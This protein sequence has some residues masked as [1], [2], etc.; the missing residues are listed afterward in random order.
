MKP[1]LPQKKVTV[2]SFKS[3]DMD[4]FTSDLKSSCLA[5]QQS[6]SLDELCRTYDN[7]LRSLLDKHAPEKTITVTE[8]P[9]TPWYND[10]INDAKKL[11]RKY[12]RLMRQPPRLTIHR[13]M[14]LEQAHV[15]TEMI[16]AAKTSYFTD[17]VNEC[18][19]DQKALFRIIGELQGKKKCALLP[20]FPTAMDAAE[21]FSEFFQ[22]K[23]STIR[24][25]LDDADDCIDQPLHNQTVLP[26]TPRECHSILDAFVPL[27]V[28][29][30]KKIVTSS[31]SKS[32]SIDPIPTWLLKEIVDD[33]VP[34][35][36]IIVN[37]SL[38]EGYFPTMFKKA[39][40]TPLLKKPSLDKEL[41]KNYRPVSN[42]SF[43]SKVTEKAAMSQVSTYVSSNRLLTKFQ[44]A[45]RPFHS[46]E[47]A[48]LRVQNDLLLSL[49]QSKGI[50]MTLLDLSAAFDTCDH[51]ILMSRLHSNMGFSGS[52]LNWFH[53]YLEDRFQSVHVNGAISSPRLLTFGFPQ[54]S[55]SG[56]QDY[57][58][59]SAEVPEVALQHGV[60]VHTY[61]DDTQLY[62]QFELSS[63]E[64][65]EAAVV[66]MEDCIEDVRKWMVMNKLKLN[67]DKSELLVITPSRQTHKCNL[68]QIKMGDCD[69]TASES[70]R[71][72]GIM[73]DNTMSMKP[74]V[75]AVVKQTN[76][77]LRS[78][79]KIRQY[80]SFDAC[81]SLIHSSISS[82]LDYGN[83]LLFG[84]PDSQ[85][86]RLQKLQNTAARI[87]TRTKKYDHITH[88]L[89]SLHWLPVARRI[90]FKINLITYKC[91]ND[92]APEYLCELI[93]VY[94][95]PRSLRSTDQNLL[96][97]P[98]T[99]LKS[100]GDRAFSKAAPTLWNKLPEDV[101]RATSL[102]DFKQKLKCHLFKLSYPDEHV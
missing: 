76:Y 55:V 98:T 74:Q 102:G 49:D 100:Y 39:L 70:I 30:V 84:L 4:K 27:T 78:V 66:R 33:I 9:Y 7:T 28:K 38:Q 63:P 8:R 46:T 6:E 12:E 75:N 42:L 79:G 83:S 72:L 93:S 40:V 18:G 45:Y 1:P 81:S 15:V 41:L 51:N 14:Y 22:N 26:L 90:E 53:S 92:Q 77:Q 34:I 2:R 10:E 5:Q 67:D 68:N 16:K 37:R 101:K 88:V 89:K 31:P 99:R 17:K 91:L 73:F 82:K 24:R 95:P 35:I 25:K 87:L 36:T 19:R 52:V 60:S 13:E 29:E 65:A 64:E 50:I 32:C 23:I 20:D 71:N 54:G 3:M 21:K 59:Y 80:L 86:N 44:S 96:S 85:I 57:S 11:R 48:L 61:A 58:Y 69:V 94:N 43:I 97:V 62:L 56:P 47:T